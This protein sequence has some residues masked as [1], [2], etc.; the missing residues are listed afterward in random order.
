MARWEWSGVGDACKNAR[1]ILGRH[2]RIKDLGAFR[3]AGSRTNASDACNYG[4]KGRRKRDLDL[5]DP[6]T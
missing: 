6:E 2:I 4:E 3:W 5:G 1:R